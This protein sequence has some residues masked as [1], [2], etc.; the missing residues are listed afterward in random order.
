MLE[1]TWASF[2]RDCRWIGKFGMIEAD[3]GNFAADLHQ[4]VVML[5]E[6][7]LVR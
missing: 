6:F 4:A 1:V 2:W 5:S 7:Q 3:C